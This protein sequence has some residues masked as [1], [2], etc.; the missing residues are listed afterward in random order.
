MVITLCSILP[1]LLSPFLADH[2]NGRT[3]AT[4]LRLSL[5]SSSVCDVCIVA[6]RYVLEQ[7]LLLTAY[8]KSYEE[9]ILTKINDLALCLEVVSRS[10][11]PLRYIQR[12]L[13]RKPLE[14]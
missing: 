11:Q 5:R 1:K 12:S 8:R 3:Y 9:L 13:S 7:K 4:V 6:K 14:I 10:C 2:T